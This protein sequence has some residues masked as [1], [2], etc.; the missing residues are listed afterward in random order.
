MTKQERYD[1][2]VAER[3]KGTTLAEIGQWLG[4]TKQRVEQILS[5]GR[6]SDFL[7]EVCKQKMYRV[8]QQH[9]QCSK[10]RFHGKGHQKTC[11]CGCGASVPI[12]WRYSSNCLHVNLPLLLQK[13]G[14]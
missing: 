3:A 14:G 9:T 6:T 10:C 13:L 1:Y 5:K 11:D 2:I 4:L 7:C 8:K 12:N